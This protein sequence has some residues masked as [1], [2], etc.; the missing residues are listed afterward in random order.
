MIAFNRTRG[1][2]DARKLFRVNV[3][4]RERQTTLGGS[5][6]QNNR[7]QNKATTGQDRRQGNMKLAN[8][9][10]PDDV[11]TISTNHRGVVR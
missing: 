1:S 10:L 6:K 4:L 11:N 2:D 8:R 7:T 9:K 3:S 5:K